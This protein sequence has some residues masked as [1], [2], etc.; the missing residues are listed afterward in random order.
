MK[1]EK[2]L[3]LK[4][5]DRNVIEKKGGIVD[6]EAETMQVLGNIKSFAQGTDC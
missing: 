6:E 3:T 1:K 5:Y 4:D 2:A